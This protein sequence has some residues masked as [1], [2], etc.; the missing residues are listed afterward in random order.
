MDDVNTNCVNSNVSFDIISC[1]MN[2]TKTSIYT[3]LLKC[4]HTIV[5]MVLNYKND[6]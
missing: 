6:S 5:W 4:T 3:N 1:M 2:E